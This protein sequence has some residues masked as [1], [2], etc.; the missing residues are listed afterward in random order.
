MF[1]DSSKVSPYRE[2]NNE[3]VVKEREDQLALDVKGLNL[4]DQAT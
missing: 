2:V 1:V 3:V 4:N